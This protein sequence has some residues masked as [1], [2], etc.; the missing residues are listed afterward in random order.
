MKVK[1]SV[2]DPGRKE[3]GK[4]RTL[5]FISGRARGGVRVEMARDVTC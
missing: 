5:L 2:K 1:S 4:C 3:S